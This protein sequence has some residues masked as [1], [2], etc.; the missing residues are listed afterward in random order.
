MNVPIKIFYARNCFEAILSLGTPMLLLFEQI[1]GAL[2]IEGPAQNYLF[3]YF[4]P[5]EITPLPLGSIGIRND[6]TSIL[7]IHKNDY[8][9]IDNYMN[10]FFPSIVSEAILAPKEGSGIMEITQLVK[11]D[12]D[13]LSDPDTKK[14]VNSIFPKKLFDGYEGDEKVKKINEWFAK[15]FFKYVTLPSCHVCG[16]PTI[17]VGQVPII[18]EEIKGFAV[19]TE[20][21]K[22]QSCG[23]HT[24]FPRYNKPSMILQTQ[25]G[26]S[27]EA[28]VALSA[29]LKTLGY[30][31]RVIVSFIDHDWVE[32]WSDKEKR[33]ICVDPVVG[34][35]DCPLLYECGWKMKLDLI[36]AV[37]EHECCDVTKR[38][39]LN[40]EALDER[41]ETNDRSAWVKRAIAFRNQ[42]W[43][44]LCNS[45]QMSK[46]KE[47]QRLDIESM[48]IK[49]QPTLDELK[50]KQF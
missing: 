2:R 25:M 9:T 23:A 5:I 46:Y 20:L 40:K 19:S 47:Y 41:R 36:I 42:E 17:L 37:S 21:Y 48:D 8:K 26:R 10:Q 16:L 35:F 15:S 24:R 30:T 44:Q 6:N 1:K 38:Y 39:V 43:L 22:C 11:D 32:V 28:S 3:W 34:T 50:P 29:I 45:S 13:L 7:I 27:H 33:Y 18:K 12:I 31:T 49:R 4:R 14:Q